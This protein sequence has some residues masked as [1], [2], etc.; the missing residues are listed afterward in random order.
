MMGLVYWLIVYRIGAVG[1]GKEGE[2]GKG[3]R[4]GRRG[5]EFTEEE[6]SKEGKYKCERVEECKSESWGR[7]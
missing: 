3:L 2:E 4:R 6:K 7:G 5:T 1:L